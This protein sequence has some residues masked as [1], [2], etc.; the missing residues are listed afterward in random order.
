MDKNNKKDKLEL[1]LIEFAMEYYNL[2]EEQI[3]EAYLSNENCSRYF[4][5][6][7]GD[8][9]CFYENE[10]IYGAWV[11]YKKSI[12]GIMRNIIPLEIPKFKVG[13]K[14]YFEEGIGEIE[15]LIYNDIGVF[16][17]Y[18]IT[19]SEELYSKFFYNIKYEEENETLKRCNLEQLSWVDKMADSYNYLYVGDSG[20]LLSTSARGKRY[21]HYTDAFSCSHIAHYFK[22]LDLEKEP[23]KLMKINNICRWRHKQ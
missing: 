15:S 14:V 3:F 18:N 23:L 12:L 8:L 13:D 17:G 11:K 22:N 21:I 16:Q 10:H 1:K 2:E 7:D 9:E 5:I 19:N 6:K 20:N 4:K